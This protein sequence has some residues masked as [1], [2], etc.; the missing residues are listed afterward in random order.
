MIVF[1]ECIRSVYI[2]AGGGSRLTL[3][4]ATGILRFRSITPLS[5]RGKPIGYLAPRAVRDEPYISSR[6]AEGTTEV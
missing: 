6:A 3:M 5:R 4:V 2:G 1:K